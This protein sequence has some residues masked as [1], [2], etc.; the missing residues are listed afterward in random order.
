MERYHPCNMHIDRLALK[1]REGVKQGGGVAQTF[2]T[3]T[4]SDGSP[5]D[6]RA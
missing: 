5:W 4:V 6:T 2:G 3:I 1:A